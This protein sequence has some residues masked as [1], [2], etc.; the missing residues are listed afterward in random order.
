MILKRFY[1]DK[2]AQASYLIGCAATGEALVVDP[3][4]DVGAY[5]RAAEAEGVRLTHVTETHIHADFVSGARELAERTGAKLFLSDEGDESWKYAFASDYDAVLLKD[6]DTFMVGNVRI[7]VL[8]TPGHTPEHLS[9]LVTDTAGADRPIGMLTGD[10]VFVGDVGRPDLLEKAAKVEGTM[11]AGARTLFRSLERFKEQPDYLQVWPGH[12]AGSACGKGLS[13][14]PHSTVGY[15]RM[16]NRALSITE[17]DGFVR[18]VLEGQPEPPRYF[19]EMKRIN[20]EGPRVLGGLERP[21]RLPEGRLAELLG[22]G[23][24]VVDTRPAA[25]FAA[26][27][28]PGTIS[29]PLNRSFTTWAGWLVPYDRPFYLLVD[30]AGPGAVDEAV[31]DLAMIGLDRVAGWF[32]ADVVAAW[33]AG[34]RE[35]QTTPQITSAELAQRMGGGGVAVLDVRGAAE[36][37][38]GHLPGVP[39]LP[40]GYLA[41]RLDEVPRDRPLVVH[42]QGGARSAIAASVLQ[43][44]GFRDVINLAGGYADWQAGGH[45]TERSAAEP[46]PAGGDR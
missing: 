43:A 44:K 45:P 13:S 18:A 27:H 21:Q 17:E 30:D 6:G 37:E 33:A 28:V 34:G 15:E 40:V 39:N 20:R 23:A 24:L 4:R 19:A 2:L 41:D 46:A 26:G 5:V 7:D 29:I 35:L 8:H 16:F 11:E 1:D 10:F 22:E 42:C 14:I 32:G 12:G 9:F 3:N 36:W 31:R 25:E 38:A